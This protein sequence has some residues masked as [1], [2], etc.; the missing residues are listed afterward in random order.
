M[1][2][3]QTVHLGQ[4]FVDERILHQSNHYIEI[5]EDSL[6]SVITHNF[7]QFYNV[8]TCVCYNVCTSGQGQIIPQEQNLVAKKAFV[9]Q[10]T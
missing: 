10:I 4:N 8:Y 3:K 7:S 6:T 5:S 9:T 1:R 2:Q